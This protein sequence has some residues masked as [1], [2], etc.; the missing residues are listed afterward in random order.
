MPQSHCTDYL[1][2][3]VASPDKEEEKKG[4]DVEGEKAPDNE[5]G[6]KGKMGGEGRGKK[7]GSLVIFAVDISGSMCTTTE[8][9]A[10]QGMNIIIPQSL[11]DQYFR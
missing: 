9:P 10:L 8:V 3:P 7:N 4:G 1:L 5:A 6:A 2:E 11:N